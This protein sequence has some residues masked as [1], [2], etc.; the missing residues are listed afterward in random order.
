MT[1][2][3]GLLGCDGFVIASDRKAVA[4]GNLIT[5]S[6]WVRQTGETRKILLRPKTK[7]F[8]CVYSINEVAG[9]IAARLVEDHRLSDFESNQDVIERVRNR[10]EEIV[11][12]YAERYR[13]L[14][15]TLMVALPRARKGVTRLWR[16]GFFPPPIVR[17]GSPRTYGG[18]AGNSAIYFAERFQDEYCERKLSVEELKGIAAHVILEGSRLNRTHIGGL[19]I[20]V[21]EDASEPRFLDNN[22]IKKIEEQSE[23]LSAKIWNHF[24]TG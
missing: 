13:P 7:D 4:E 16:V 5:D 2:Q 12:G 1:W 10:C 9:D 8:I 24:K 21:C 19:D 20:L 6:R 22:E 23:A 17:E 18:D 15:P 11:H 3:V 14:G